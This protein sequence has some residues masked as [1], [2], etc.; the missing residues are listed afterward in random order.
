MATLFAI[1]QKQPLENRTKLIFPSFQVWFSNTPGTFTLGVLSSPSSPILYAPPPSR[2]QVVG[3]ALNAQARAVVGGGGAGTG[4]RGVRG[5]GLGPRRER[6]SPPLQC[7]GA[8]RLP[9]SPWS[10]KVS[11]GAASATRG[12]GRRGE[13]RVNAGNLA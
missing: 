7:A 6:E 13:A 1:P 5:L 8:W 12:S 9:V 10:G 2:E 4:G 11:G 3:S